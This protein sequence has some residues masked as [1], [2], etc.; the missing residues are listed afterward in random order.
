M[1]VTDIC[2]FCKYTEIVADLFYLIRKVEVVLCEVSKKDVIQ[3][4]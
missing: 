2:I 3:L 4:F 1:K